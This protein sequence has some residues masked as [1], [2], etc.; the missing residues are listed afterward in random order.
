VSSVDPQSKRKSKEEEISIAEEFEEI[1]VEVPADV[2]VESGSKR[3]ASL[4]PE[5]KE[6]PPPKRVAESLGGSSG[7]PV[8]TKARKAK[9]KGQK[10]STKKKY[11]GSPND[12]TE[13]KYLDVEDLDVERS[14][15]DYIVPAAPVPK[16][17]RP[18]R[19][20]HPGNEP[21]TDPDKLPKGWTTLEPDL[22]PS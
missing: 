11:K 22:D 13:R 7:S 9:K 14:Y 10:K 6:Q 12:P 18:K 15:V 2:H 19:W 17:E 16:P 5:T 20:K 21:L 3:K 4:T 1:D 8:Y